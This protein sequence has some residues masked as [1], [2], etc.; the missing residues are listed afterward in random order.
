MPIIKD[1]E[2]FFDIDSKIDKEIKKDFFFDYSV[3]EIL[4]GFNWLKNIHSVLDY[5]C[6]IGVTLDLYLETTKNFSAVVYGV[7]ISA[8]AIKRITDKYNADSYHF[9]RIQNN[10]IPQI[11][12]GSIDGCYMINVLHHSEDHLVIFNEI[13]RKLKTG[14]KF[15]L[16]DLSYNNFIINFGRNIFIYLPNFFKKRFSNDLVIDGNIPAK[17]N[18]DIE[19]TTNQL[20]AAG[21]EI[22]EMG[23]G[24]L[25]VFIFDWLNK[26]FFIKK[27]P[28]YDQM[29]KLSNSMETFLLK[30]AFFQK[31]SHIFYIKCLKSDNEN[32]T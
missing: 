26:L 14:G 2:Y 3:K 15:F 28:F 32:I 1:Q 22:E 10:Q 6:G 7:D 27:I 18:V 9:F 5:G 13:F 16:S 23:F 20:K 29:L 24:H 8:G 12:D 17:Y 4:L 21:F 19:E 11:A 31:K 30:H 25:F